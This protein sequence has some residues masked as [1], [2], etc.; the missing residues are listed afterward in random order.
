MFTCIKS[1]TSETID[2]SIAAG[3][4]ETLDISK[5]GANSVAD[6]CFNPSQEVEL[7]KCFEFPQEKVSL[8]YSI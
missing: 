5:F 3:N 8:L 1:L 2:D 4:D 7:S 6:N